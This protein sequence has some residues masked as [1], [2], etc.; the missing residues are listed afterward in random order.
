MGGKTVK[1][2]RYF[3]VK[4]NRLNVRRIAVER[5]VGTVI[6]CSLLHSEGGG[7]ELA[8]KWDKRSSKVGFK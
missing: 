4:H 1:N 5:L 8:P 7:R 3:R 6:N 2:M